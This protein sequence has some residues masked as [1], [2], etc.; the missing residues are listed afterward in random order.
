MWATVAVPEKLARLVLAEWPGATTDERCRA[1]QD[2]RHAYDDA[3]P[4]VL[5]VDFVELLRYEIAERRRVH[6]WPTR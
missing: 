6:G 4:D 3:H 2:A 1:W 5:A